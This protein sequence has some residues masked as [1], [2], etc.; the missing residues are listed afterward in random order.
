MHISK[1]LALRKR[2]LTGQI[3]R[4]H[5]AERGDALVEMAIL[6][7]LLT[8]LL[9]GA[10]EVALAVYTSIEV[11]SAALAGVQYGAQSA[12]A[13]GDTTGIQNAAA[14]DAANIS[15]STPTVSKS[16]ICANGASS[17]CLSTDCS[18]SYI[19]T[20]LKVQTQATFS[21]VIRFP[22]IPTSFTFNGQAIQKV[23]Q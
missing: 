4:T 8:L 16:C 17:T 19:E 10:F 22:G 5:A 15:L 18:G 2:T 7:P 13:A 14:A 6:L 12:A 21:P 11:S 20:I 9:L 1:S 3:L 23:L